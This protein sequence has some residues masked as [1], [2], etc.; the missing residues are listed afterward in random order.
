[1]PFLT[2]VHSGYFYTDVTDL[3]YIMYIIS[4]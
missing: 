2:F 3:Q 1:M 4:S